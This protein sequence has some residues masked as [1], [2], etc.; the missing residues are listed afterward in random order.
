[1]N[2]PPS[3]GRWS[4]F[5]ANLLLLALALPAAAQEQ[6]KADVVVVVDTSTS[7]REPGMDPER[8][9]LLVTK[10]LTDIVPGDLAVVRLLDLHSDE[11]VLPSR[12]TGETMPC[13]ED[14]TRTCN[15]VEEAINWEAAAR[16][17]KLGALV[18][19]SRGDT[20]YKQQLERHLEQRA[21]NSLFHLALRA[22]QGIFDEHRKAGGQSRDVPRTIIWLS[23]GTSDAPDAV[24]EVL[25]ELAAEGT[26]VE[27]IVFGRGDTALA[28]SAGLTPLQVS[29]PAGIMK[30]FANA[31]RRIVQAPYDIDNLVSTQPSFEMKP[32]VDEAWVV[33]YGD[34]SL[35]DVRLDSPKGSIQA[36]YATDRWAGAGAYKVAYLQ[37]P[38][39]G[40]WTVYAQGGGPG[41][42]YAVVQRSALTPVLL[43]PQRAV[44]GSRV[45]LVA[46]IRAGLHGDLITDPQVLREVTVT[47]ELQGQIVRLVDDGSQDDA[48]LNDGRFT[49]LVTFHGTGKVPVRVRIRSPLVDRT[50]DATVEVSGSFRYTGGPIDVDLGMLGVDSEACRPLALHAEHKGEVP[51]ELQALRWLPSGHGLEVRLPAGSLRPGGGALAI[52]SGDSLQ[53]CLKTSPRAPSSIAQGEP[54]L[55]LRVAGSEASEQQVTLRLHWQVHGLSFW[56]RWGWLILLILGLLVLLFVIGGFV[57]PQRFQGALAVTYVPERDELDEQTPQPVKQ[58]K[59]VRIGFYRDARAFLHPDFRLSGNPQGAL[60]GLYA[61][62]EG[63]RVT[64]GRGLSLFRE[65]LDGDWENVPAPEGRRA[66]AGDIYRIGDRGPYF[67][68]ATFRGRG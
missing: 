38:A 53:V 26:V 47:A 24:R 65:T 63:A 6:A 4:N 40:R 18:R 61:E 29:S 35:G 55:E 60:A 1:M 64:P 37:R 54:W 12:R 51:F 39:A 57:L 48:A 9:S 23:D 33:V 10:L 50:A 41:V 3:R 45:P 25:H 32:N 52:K 2:L 42:A 11:D 13:S 28:K 62:K 30:A 46:G 8:A 66:R 16:S 34:D 22:G 43:A 5:T 7:M 31:F 15:R 44:S 27:P 56:Q 21:N 14:P 19:P 68:I 36:D 59:G 67:R 17:K 58:W 49:A 20:G